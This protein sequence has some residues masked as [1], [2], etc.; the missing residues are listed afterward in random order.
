MLCRRLFCVG[1][2]RLL[3][4][5]RFNLRLVDSFAVFCILCLYSKI[6]AWLALLSNTYCIAISTLR[7]K[8]A[9]FVQESSRCWDVIWQITARNSTSIEQFDFI[10]GA[11]LTLGKCKTTAK[12]VQFCLSSFAWCHKKCR[13]TDIS[14]GWFLVLQCLKPKD[15]IERANVYQCTDNLSFIYIGIACVW[16]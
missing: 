5:L 3:D 14:L 9:I 11:G 7:G 13:Q 6:S 2:A 16:H 4:S 10:N 8:S 12:V 15:I 1:F